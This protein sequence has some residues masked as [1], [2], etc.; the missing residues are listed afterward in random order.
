MVPAQWVG[1]SCN[2]SSLD[3]LVFEIAEIFHGGEDL[4]IDQEQML[5]DQM[6]YSCFQGCVHGIRVESF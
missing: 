5:G 3:I 2:V 1:R 6:S 4:G